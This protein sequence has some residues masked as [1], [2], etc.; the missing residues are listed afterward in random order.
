MLHNCCETKFHNWFVWEKTT[1]TITTT[2]TQLV[3]LL[4]GRGG[5]SEGDPLHSFSY[6]WSEA[7]PPLPPSDMVW[8][9]AC[10]LPWGKS[11]SSSRWLSV[12]PTLPSKKQQATLLPQAIPWADSHDR[13]QSYICNTFPIWP[14]TNLA[15]SL[16]I[17]VAPTYTTHTPC[18]FL[19]P[20]E[21]SPWRCSPRYVAYRPNSSLSRSPWGNWP[22]AW[23]VAG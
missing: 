22:P 1:I 14:T 5:D 19:G 10:L 18:S 23:I 12:A 11:H 8:L 4:E 9:L 15:S 3:V 20:L 6:V 21:A 2:K 13:N 17:S 7:P 16:Q